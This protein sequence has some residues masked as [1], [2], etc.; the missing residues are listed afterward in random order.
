MAEHDPA[1][2]GMP[3]QPEWRASQIVRVVAIATLTVLVI[4][5]LLE[6]LLQIRTLL[7]WVLIGVVL[8][9]ALQPAVGWLERHRFGRVSASLLV[10]F[11]TIAAPI[12]IVAALV[13]PVV[14]Q[15]DDFIRAL[16]QL[17]AKLFGAGGRLN[18][19]EVRFHVL[20]RVSNVSPQDVTN[21]LSGSQGSLVGSA[22]QGPPPSP[23]P[24]SPS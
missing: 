4:L 21:I 8:A 2:R 3:A 15:A 9:I 20:E 22:D 19:L 23:P 5:G 7:L 11:G 10:S 12:G 24:R 1:P 16:P 18:F 13:Y 6:F 17:L 14:F